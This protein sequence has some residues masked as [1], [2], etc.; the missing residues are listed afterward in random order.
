[1]LHIIAKLHNVRYIQYYE[2]LE[3]E[4]KDQNTCLATLK[5]ILLSMYQTSSNFK[6]RHK[7]HLFADLDIYGNKFKSWAP[8]IPERHNRVR[9]ATNDSVSNR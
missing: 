6:Y 5:P 3:A 1:M 8:I 9:Q 4:H 7:T 2:Q